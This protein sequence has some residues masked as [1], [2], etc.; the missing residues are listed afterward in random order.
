MDN[1]WIMG[2][3]HPST[4]LF[5]DPTPKRHPL[6]SPHIYQK[7]RKECKNDYIEAFGAVYGAKKLF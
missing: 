4:I 1:K 2:F 3:H 6:I 7:M 5:D